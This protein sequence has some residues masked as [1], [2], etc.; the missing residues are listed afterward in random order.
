[1]VRAIRVRRASSFASQACRQSGRTCGLEN[2]SNRL[3]NRSESLRGR[4][5]IICA[6]DRLQ[7]R[8]GVFRSCNMARRKRSWSRLPVGP[9]L[10]IRRRLA[11]FTATSA[12]PFDWGKATEEIRC[13]IPHSW[14]KFF[15]WLATNSGPPSLASSSGTPK[16]A[17]QVR[18]WRT[19]PAEPPR[20]VPAVELNTSTHPDRRSP[21]TK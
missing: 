19:R 14:R 2:F 15:V 7:S 1:M 13:L 10:D 20:S 18:R 16:V 4:P 11:D 5:K 9:V 17:K 8:S 6:G 12:R 3:M 21:T